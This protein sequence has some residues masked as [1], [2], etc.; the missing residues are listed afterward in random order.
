MPGKIDYRQFLSPMTSNGYGCAMCGHPLRRG[1]LAL[2]CADCGAII[3]AR[4]ADHMED[5]ECEDDEFEF[6]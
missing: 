6:D 2:D 4:C 5:H 3:C 1:D